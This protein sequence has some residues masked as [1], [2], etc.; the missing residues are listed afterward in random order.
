MVWI[1]TA[2]F[3]GKL[4]LRGPWPGSAVALRADPD[5]TTHLAEMDRAVHRI[6]R[7]HVPETEAEDRFDPRAAPAR[8][9]SIVSLR[10]P[11]GLTSRPLELADET[12]AV[13]RCHA[14][15]HPMGCGR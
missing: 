5:V 12:R 7:G 15:R 2:S 11:A 6:I 4:R 9:F 13:D 1:M 14:R 3:G 8:P 10:A